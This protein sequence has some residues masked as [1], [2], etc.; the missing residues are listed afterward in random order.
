[1]ATLANELTDMVIDN[2]HD[3]P[4]TLL[5]CALVSRSWYPSSRAHFFENITLVPETF[6]SIILGRIWSEDDPLEAGNVLLWEPF[7]GGL[8]GDSPV[9]RCLPYIQQLSIRGLR[10][11]T[12]EDSIHFGVRL[13]REIVT[14]CPALQDRSLREVSCARSEEIQTDT[15]G[16]QLRTLSLLGVRRWGFLWHDPDTLPTTIEMFSAFSTIK[17]LV[18]GIRNVYEPLSNTIFGQHYLTRVL[19]EPTP[20]LP[21]VSSMSLRRADS[22]T[23]S[24]FLAAATFRPRD[25]LRS[26]IMKNL[27]NV[28]F[29]SLARV[30]SACPNLAHLDIDPTALFHHT[31]YGRWGSLVSR[32]TAPNWNKV[33]FSLCRSL[34]SLRIPISIPSTPRFPHHEE[35]SMRFSTTIDWISTILPPTTE[36]LPADGSLATP[37]LKRL[38]VPILVESLTVDNLD[39]TI[40]DKEIPQLW[41]LLVELAKKLPQ[42]EIIESTLGE[43][44]DQDSWEECERVRE[45]RKDFIENEYGDA[46]GDRVALVLE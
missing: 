25:S 15:S 43:L 38:S 16:I 44:D 8:K 22:D 26:L 1:M 30:L 45:M 10:E 4:T 34:T 24:L 18:V 29:D 11:A 20:F 33:P 39:D 41:P 9:K 5:S 42:L 28:S 19:K 46:F 3:D 40:T 12:E 2:L 37:I 17:H 32:P 36:N 31:G 13:L 21:T 27:D 35:V 23:L 7:L 6:R 14:A